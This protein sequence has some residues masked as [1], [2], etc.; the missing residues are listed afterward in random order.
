MNDILCFLMG[1]A[2]I[3]A[4]V[5]ILVGFG[6]NVLGIIFGLIMIGKGAMSFL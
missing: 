2:D 1:V 6:S 5:L 3:V 4:G